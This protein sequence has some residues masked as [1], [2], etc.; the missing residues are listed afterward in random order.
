LA[1]W[2]KSSK[3]KLQPINAKSENVAESRM[4]KKSICVEAIGFGHAR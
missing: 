4:F 3:E 1:N 2:A